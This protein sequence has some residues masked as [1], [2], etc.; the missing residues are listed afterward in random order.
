MYF[1]IL[2]DPDSGELSYLLAD[3]D[4]GEAVLID[5]RSADLPVLRA[6]KTGWIKKSLPPITCF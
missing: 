1:R 5:P 6:L 4:A 3:L 2:H